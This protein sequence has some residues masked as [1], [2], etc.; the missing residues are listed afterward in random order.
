MRVM[1]VGRKFDRYTADIPLPCANGAQG[2]RPLIADTQLSSRLNLEAAP[3][4][5]CASC[6]LVT[7]TGCKEHDRQR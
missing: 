1:K 2:M 6:L 5:Q 7:V 3:R 4:G